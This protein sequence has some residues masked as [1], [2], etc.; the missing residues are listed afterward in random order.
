VVTHINGIA[1]SPGGFVTLSDGA[2]VVLMPDGTLLIMPPAA[3]A[4]QTA[5]VTTNFSYTAQSAAGV[6]DTAFVT[7]T[8]VPCFTHGTRIRTERGEVPVEALAVGDEHFRGKCMRRLNEF[9]EAGGTTVFVSH[10]TYTPAR[11]GSAVTPLAGPARPAEAGGM[12][13]RSRGAAAGVP[14]RFVDVTARHGVPGEA[15][16]MGAA[17][18]AA[19]DDI[20]NW[21]AEAEK[22]QRYL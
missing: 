22:R 18:A 2:L 21:E 4:G 3:Q 12:H 17:A 19:R 14:L 6:S 10:E 16:A 11:G 8:T 13:R 1:V 9:S 7:V 15:R 5:P 20:V